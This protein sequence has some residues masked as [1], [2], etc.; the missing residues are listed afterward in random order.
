MYDQ[1][2][3]R[4][5]LQVLAQAFPDK[6]HLHQ[7]KAAL[8]EYRDLPAQ[9][10]LSAVQ[11]LRL[12]GK[13]DGKFLPDGDSI[14][15]AAALYATERERRLEITESERTLMHTRPGLRVFICHSSGDKKEVST[16]YHRLRRDGFAPWLDEENILPGQGWEAEIRQ[17]VRDS[18]IVVVCLSRS[19]ITKEGYVQTEIKLALDVAEEKPEGTIF[20]IPARLE[21]CK[22]P[23]RLVGF[24][25]V[26]LFDTRG[27]DRLVAA[28]R[29]REIQLHGRPE[30][31]APSLPAG[32]P[33]KGADLGDPDLHD[34]EQA[35][36]SLK[37]LIKQPSHPLALHDLVM[38]VANGARA[39]IDKSGILEFGTNPS[40]DELVRRVGVADQ[41]TD[42][43]AH[44]FVIGCRWGDREH[45]R[46]FSRALSCIAVVP[47]PKDK[48]YEIWENVARY[49]ALRV[50]YA[51]GVA[52]CA[53]DSFAVL[54]E[55]LVGPMVRMRPH[56]QE[57]PLVA[58][59]HN[60][61]GFMQDC[62]KWLPGKERH[63][64]PVSAHLEESLGRAFH[65]IFTSDE[66][67]SINFDKFE[68]FQALI[69]ADLARGLQFGFWAPLG[70]FIWR[71]QNLFAQT[72]N[73]IRSL[74]QNWGP[75]QA[76]LFSGSPDRAADLVGKL[77][78]FA[79]RVCGQLGI[80]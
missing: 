10:W 13:L 26:D 27:Y 59:L 14:A 70:S 31:S 23:Q 38:P 19:S 48:F 25:W 5:I 64:V 60:R 41:A 69:Y 37:E 16:L 47:S 62:W 65:Q 22:V 54:R 39:K 56:E 61:S 68:F 51:G 71:R 33:R 73:D 28:L 4:K 9:Q 30:T 12:E 63:Y 66:E 35:V 53:D 36:A 76:E 52:A 43:L 15:D 34:V 46:T 3:A 74:R 80:S 57:A 7:V 67:I 72:Q 32:Q 1:T 75:V 55:V 6:L 79:S 21:D 11:A 50:M 44:L 40:G 8:P 17:A 42:V 78:E 77:E 49:A 45:A 24:H 20:V 29:T 18:D 58:T 2:L